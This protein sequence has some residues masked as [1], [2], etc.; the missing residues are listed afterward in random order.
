M[1]VNEALIG[2]IFKPLRNLLVKG[3]TDHLKSTTYQCITDMLHTRV[4]KHTFP[5][6]GYLVA[7]GKLWDVCGTS[8]VKN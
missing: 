5:R 3:L 6:S 4:L 1:G 2:Y 8:L 7:G